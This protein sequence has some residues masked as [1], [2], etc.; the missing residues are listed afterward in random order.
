MNIFNKKILKNALISRGI[1][2]DNHYLDC[3]LDLLEANASNTIGEKHHAI[4]CNSYDEF[5]SRYYTVCVMKY[6][7]RATARR[8]AR[9]FAAKEDSDNFLVKLVRYP[10]HYLA[11][12]Y[13]M[14]CCRE[15]LISSNDIIPLK[16]TDVTSFPTS[17]NDHLYIALNYINKVKGDNHD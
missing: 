6:K 5:K 13:F 1:C 15:D 8:K 3:Y 12:A 14:L 17:I 4:P 11:H 10:D 9:E 2:E 16:Y 7:C